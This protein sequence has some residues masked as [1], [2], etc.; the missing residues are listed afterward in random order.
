MVD[1]GAVV[2]VVTREKRDERLLDRVLLLL[3]KKEDKKQG[4]DRH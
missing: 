4:R 1:A 2:C 3:L